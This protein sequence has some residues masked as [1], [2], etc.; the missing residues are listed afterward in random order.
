MTSFISTTTV[1]LAGVS[2]ATVVL[3]SAVSARGFGGG[4]GGGGIHASRP[5][6][7]RSFASHNVFRQPSV[8]HQPRFAGS[9]FAP[10]ASFAPHIAS[11]S[12]FGRSSF[13]HP[14][15]LAHSTPSSLGQH[16][17][18]AA[19]RINFASIP[20]L[21][22]LGHTPS[23]NGNLHALNGAHAGT[24]TATSVS[25]STANSNNNNNN[26]NKTNSGNSTNSNNTS[27][28][29]TNSNNNTGGQTASGTGTNTNTGAILTGT[30]NVNGKNNG[31][32]ITGNNNAIDSNNKTINVTN[33]TSIRRGGG[34]RGFGGGGFVGGGFVTPVSRPASF[35]P[36]PA[37]VGQTSFAALPGRLSPSTRPAVA[38]ASFLN[39]AFL[40]TIT[41]GDVMHFVQAYNATIVAGPDAEGVYRL[42]VSDQ[43]LPSS[44]LQELADS[45]R[46][47]TELVQAVGL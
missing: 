19:N 2:L 13:N 39:V 28:V 25:T 29:N 10:H 8:S 36:G 23:F 45:M 15:S 21:T 22:S 24:N 41:A 18:G 6:P 35:D 9:S 7:T 43:A 47:Q 14:L 1:L 3:P 26:N 11:A 37:P 32:T 40:P 38:S 44:R 16:G 34:G 27:T 30:G 12:G 33:N 31:N 5:A 17:F 42:K 4:H 46:G 20:H